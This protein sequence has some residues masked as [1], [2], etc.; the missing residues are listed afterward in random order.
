MKYFYWDEQ[1]PS[2]DL[3]PLILLYNNI[4]LH[5]EYASIW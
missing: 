2:A 1:A 4:L 5:D 3:R